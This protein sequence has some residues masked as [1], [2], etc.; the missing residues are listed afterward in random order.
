MTPRHYSRFT[1][2]RQTQVTLLSYVYTFLYTS[3][4]KILIACF[5]G[6]FV[7][8]SSTGD[9][10][11]TPSANSKE[12]LIIPPFDI[13]TTTPQAHLQTGLANILAT[14]VTQKTNHIVSPHNATTE[15]LTAL[16]R[17]QDYVT[18]QEILH[19]MG[20]TYLLAGTLTEKKQGYEIIVHVFGHRPTA[21]IS[22]SQT[23]NRL[24]HALSALDDLALD[25]AEK[26][27][28]IPRP[29]KAE[30]VVTDG[31]EGFHTAH[32]E[33][34]F[35]EGKYSAKE[36]NQDILKPET[37]RSDFGI[38]SSNK[39]TLPSSTALAMAVGDL[40]N[41]GNE[42]FVILE[43][44]NIIIYH[45]GTDAFQRIASQPLARHLGLHT[46]HLADL[47]NNGLQEIYIGAS[48]G[49]LPA[50][51]IL[52]WDGN[53][54]VLYQNAPYYLRPGID[55]KGEPILLGQEN[56]FQENKSRA[57]Y[58]LKRELNG[59]LKKIQRI[60]IPPGFNIYDFLRV[61]LELDGNPE[62]IGMT[63]GNKLV[64]LDNAGRI[65][66][67]SEKDYGASRE[68][69]GTLSSTIDGDRYQSNNPKSIWMHTRIIPQDLNKDQTPE[70]ILGRNHL[71]KIPFFTRFRSFDGSSITALRWEN[72]TMKIFWESPQLAGY[73][74]D[75]Q[76]IQ[77]E[78]QPN[79]FSLFSLE[80][81]DT[82]NLMS[83][84]RTKDSFVHT[85][86]FDNHHKK[87]Q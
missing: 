85:Y 1:F 33:R 86:L 5:A 75:F 8:I 82:G 43:R 69:L 68:I 79:I 21:Q 39:I 59:S 74:V 83:F 56:V 84:W 2:Y 62:F 20:N 52:E 44:A 29:E 4:C 27:F 60:T 34:I 22:L 10:A 51:Q 13:Q 70:I 49:T 25:I 64:V 76:I 3:A 40:N 12:R 58:S 77:R 30:I 19:S 78:K 41:D 54:R 14:R 7:L 57:F 53:F 32:P 80:Q 15:K 26:I 67:K 42:E 31:L 38:L 35:K 72:N 73:T 55:T 23:F 47:D 11:E 65:L 16:L 17:Q 45:K 71:A 50:S 63:R 36:V 66:W 81:E 48:N 28:F 87:D 6:C 24:D 18:V 61:D 9:T 37:K 46:I